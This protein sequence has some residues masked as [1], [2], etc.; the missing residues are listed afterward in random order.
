MVIIWQYCSALMININIS[1]INSKMS[2][3][4]LRL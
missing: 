1:V 3:L 2:Y 4:I